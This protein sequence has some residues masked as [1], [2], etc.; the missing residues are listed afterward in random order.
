M[1]LNSNYTALGEFQLPFANR[2][3]HMAPF[4]LDN[5][6]MPSEFEDY[7]Q[8]VQSLC[9][10][11]GATKGE[12]Y[13]TI[14]ER[15]VKGGTTHRKPRPHVDG[16]WVAKENSWRKPNWL[17]GDLMPMIVISN[18][19]GCRAWKGKFETFIGEGGDLSHLNLPEGE[20]LP[21][22]M[23]YFLS[24]ECIHESIAIN[25][26]AERSFLRITLPTKFN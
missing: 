1:K 11:V 23:A 17:Y 19:I 10:K 12:A 7:T 14:D 26:D 5:L 21:A 25:L 22:N 15:F 16:F 2:Q 6:V 4:E 18:V 9:D 13:L 3:I 24:P 8:I 20:I